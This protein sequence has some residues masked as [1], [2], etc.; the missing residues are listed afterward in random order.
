M[1]KSLQNN[2]DQCESHRAGNSG[3]RKGKWRRVTKW[4]HEYYVFVGY[5]NMVMTKVVYR[6]ISAALQ[7]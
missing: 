2:V 6:C 1:F 4:N 7:W 3:V 5:Y